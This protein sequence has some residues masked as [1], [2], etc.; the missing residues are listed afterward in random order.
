[1][2]ALTKTDLD[3]AVKHL[4]TAIQYSDQARHIESAA[5]RADMAVMLKKVE[6]HDRLIFEINARHETPKYSEDDTPVFVLRRGN[7]KTM[8][9]GLSFI[10]GLASFLHVVGQEGARIGMIIFHAFNASKK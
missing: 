5:L 4:N 9:L 3:D 6:D 2:R 8:S 10:V 1:M 7:I